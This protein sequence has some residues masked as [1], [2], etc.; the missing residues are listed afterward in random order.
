MERIRLLTIGNSFSENALTDLE[1]IAASTGKVAFDVGRASLGGC[2][3][4]KHW[5][6]AQYTR[7]CP[8]HKTYRIRPGPDGKPLE[9]NLQEALVLERW[10]FVTLQQFSGKSWRP[11]TFQ[12]YLSNLLSLV[13]EL[14]P[15]AAALLHQTWAYRTDSSFLPQNGLTQEGMFA[16]IRDTYNRYSAELGCGILPSG[17]A[18]QRA[19]RAPGHAFTWPDPDFDYQNA[20]AP[21]LPRQDHS[22]AAGWYWG[23][24]DTPEGLPELRLDANHLNADGCYL[25]GCVWFERLTGID[26]RTVS[27]RP[28]AMA[29]ATAEFLRGIAHETCL[30]YPPIRRG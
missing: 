1:A 17:D 14:A 11:E 28:E 5:N 22:L 10:D 20:L 13:R 9:A 23:I 4:A 24:N 6:L 8:Q 3:L 2:P 7:R 21:A 15:Q 27:F 16:R 25:A 30:A 19:R 18:V 12:P 26:A 29:A